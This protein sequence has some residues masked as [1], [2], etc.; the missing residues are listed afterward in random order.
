MEEVIM[1]KVIMEEVIMEEVK[2]DELIFND[3]IE[4]V[5]KRKRCVKQPYI[6]GRESSKPHDAD[7][8][9]KYYKENLAKKIVCDVCCACVS[10]GNLSK[11]KK[12][13]SCLEINR[14]LISEAIKLN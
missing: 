9:V 2:E 11:H 13:K 14:I 5:Q 10:K 3:V 6:K 7:Y 12:T 1:D 8:F 4:V